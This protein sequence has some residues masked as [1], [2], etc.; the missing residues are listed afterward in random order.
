MSVVALKYTKE[1]KVGEGTYAEVFV[2]HNKADDSQIAVKMI[3]VANF[4]DGLDMSAIREVKFLQE[5]H[6]ANV[7]ELLDV[8]VSEEGNLNLVL[9]F[10]P[11]DLE[12]VIKDKA[13]VF[14][15]ADVKA[16]L[17]MLL[18]GVHHCHRNFVLHRDL[19]P[20]NLLI[21]P[22]GQLKIADFGLGRAMAFQPHEKMTPTVVTRWYR[23]P[24][25]LLGARHYTGAVDM[26]AVG[27]I[28]AEMMLRV[29][30]LA[31][32]SDAEQLELTFKALG[33]PSVAQWPRLDAL[34]LYQKTDAFKIKH[35]AP[36]RQQMQGLFSAASDSALDLL[37]AM[38]AMDPMRRLSAKDALFAPYF[39]EKPLPTKPA[40]LPNHA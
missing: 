32:P 3:K 23:A 25:L 26:W 1:K 15:P 37:T 8:F 36:T 18:R 30:Y 10:L 11:S 28:F 16:W 9:E 24:E 12:V 2:G 19:K 27:M 33:T 4:K 35:P 29:P 7:I 17:L 39:A 22:D 38:I 14:A 13:L 31:A 5:M 40:E 20:S 6:H 34:P 21:A